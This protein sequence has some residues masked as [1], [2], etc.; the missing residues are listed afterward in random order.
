MPSDDD[1]PRPGQTSINPR[2]TPHAPPHH[3]PAAAKA[4]PACR[5]GATAPPAPGHNPTHPHGKQTSA[6]YPSGPP[7]RFSP[8]LERAESRVGPRPIGT[9][10]RDRRERPLLGSQK[11]DTNQE[12]GGP[13]SHQKTPPN[14]PDLEKPDI[15]RGAL[16]L[17]SYEHRQHSKQPR[18]LL[19]RHDRHHPRL[20][21]A[22]ATPHRCAKTRK[23]YRSR[24][25]RARPASDWRTPNAYRE[26]GHNPRSET[27]A[28]NAQGYLSVRLGR[29]I[30][31][32]GK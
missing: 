28:C 13:N 2:T 15:K 3:R 27:M 30:P 8:V 29:T 4:C 10:R 21:T 31:L 17:W 23:E 32:E 1:R 19:V 7:A 22:D 26:R 20:R 16:G 5:R 11:H 6:T 9:G 24:T 25:A 12:A 18:L 14:T